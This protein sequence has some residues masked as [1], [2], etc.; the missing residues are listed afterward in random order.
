MNSLSWPQGG[1]LCGTREA[2]RGVDAWGFSANNPEG[3]YSQ[4]Y[5]RAAHLVLINAVVVFATA[6]CPSHPSP[7]TDLLH[8]PPSKTTRLLTPAHYSTPAPHSNQSPVEDSFIQKL[9][10][11]ITRRQKRPKTKKPQ[12]NAQGFPVT[13]SDKYPV[14]RSSLF[15]TAFPPPGPARAAPIHERTKMLAVLHASLLLSQLTLWRN[16]SHT[17]HAA[18]VSPPQRRPNQQNRQREPRNLAPAG[19]ESPMIAVAAAAAAAA[20]IIIPPYPTAAAAAVVVVVV[21]G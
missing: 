8:I 10:L 19:T 13:P 18:T 3:H 15:Q 11:S 21:A 6:S 4:L 20:A 9:S 14:P 16:V 7:F 5:Q 2:P 17:P 1:Y 12:K